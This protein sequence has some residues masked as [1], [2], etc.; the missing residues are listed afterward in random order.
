MPIEHDDYEEHVQDHYEDPYH[1][2]T[3]DT[4]THMAEGTNPNC[5]DRIVV[6][7]RLNDSGK[8][9][10]AWFDGEG[11]VISQASA[12]ML[13]EQV[14]GKMIEDVKAIT[15]EQVLER[16]GSA[17]TPERQKCC[18]LSLDT[19]QSALNSRPDDDFDSLAPSGP[20]LGE[21]Q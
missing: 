18:L 9:N 19:L 3:L 12:S 8:I 20:S 16:I 7:L 21:E 4:A 1:R 10:E 14:E 6:T 13:M 2:G 15:A 11:C 17:M 5:G